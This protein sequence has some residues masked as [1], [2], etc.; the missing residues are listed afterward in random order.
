MKKGVL[1][2]ILM[3]AALSVFAQT[4]MI[5]DISGTV[6]LKYAGTQNFIVASKGD[7]IRQDTIVSTGFRSMALLEIG[8]T[9]ITVRPLTRLTMKEISTAANTEILYVNLQSGRVKVDVNPPAGTKAVMNVAS[10]SATASVRGTSFW[11]DSRNLSVLEGTVAFSSNRGPAVPVPA[12]FHST[13]SN[14]GKA[15]TVTYST[16]SNTGFGG[17]GGLLPGVSSSDNN[18]GTG[19]I[20]SG[21]S[22]YGS[23]PTD[24]SGT[25]VELEY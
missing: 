6:E 19:T 1:V 9:V 5:R 18:Q 23:T 7:A 20:Q 10:P 24:V 16:G 12:S 22:N 2:V 21:F 17:D 11:F 14:N 4:G 15:S 8:C 3:F 13:V 25:D